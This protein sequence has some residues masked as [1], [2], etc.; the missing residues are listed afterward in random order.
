MKMLKWIA[1]WGNTFK[2]IILFFPFPPNFL[3]C[4]LW[5]T[6]N[7]NYTEP[8]KHLNRKERKKWRKGERGGGRKPSCLPGKRWLSRNLFYKSQ[9]CRSPY[10]MKHFDL[11]FEGLAVW[12]LSLQQEKSRLHK[13]RH[14]I[15][16]MFPLETRKFSNSPSSKDKHQLSQVCPRPAQEKLRTRGS[17]R[18]NKKT[19]RLHCKCL[20]FE[21]YLMWKKIK[22]DIGM[23]NSFAGFL[24]SFLLR[25][26]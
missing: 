21:K 18:Q 14:H 25:W 13:Q 6:Q 16:V 1:P 17:S 3:S 10:S 20:G 11:R 9:S 24:F 26:D 15:S 8:F 19:Y 22:R 12:T 7:V 23:E 2:L 4:S 5:K